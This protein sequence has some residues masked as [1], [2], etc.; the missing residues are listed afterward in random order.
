M[1]ITLALGAAT[2]CSSG[3]DIQP[4]ASASHTNTPS[5][6]SPGAVAPIDSS[7]LGAAL[8]NLAF[9]G[10]KPTSKNAAGT[11]SCLV[12]AVRAA[13]LSESAQALVVTQAGDDWGHTAAAMR[14]KISDE[15]AARFLGSELRQKV[16][17]CMATAL[18]VSTAKT[19]GPAV[20]VKP[21]QPAPAP[22]ASAPNFTATYDSKPKEEITSVSQIQP[23]LVSMLSAFAQ[24]PEQKAK[25]ATAGAC[26]SDAV[27]RA[28]FSAGTLHF[29][30][31]G[32]PLGSGSVVDQFA[33]DKDKQLWVS[34]AFTETMSGCLRS[35]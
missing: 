27:L 5:G 9:A 2:G 11:S 25:I 29:L 35:A 28:G 23:G 19:P 34:A 31:G 26:L 24:T 17:A 16:D 18:G 1:V 33:T 30:V 8:E 15:D 4:N 7:A 20:T 21:V 6:A 12:D 22:P 32:A 10:Q 3:S 13:D 14:A